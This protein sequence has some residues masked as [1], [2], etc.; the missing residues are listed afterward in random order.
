M[1]FNLFIARR[2]FLSNRGAKKV[3]RPAILIAT[4]GV[5]IG[6]AVMII[7][8]CVVLGFKQE[9][10]S[11]VI[12][13]GSHVQI[14]NYATLASNS[15]QPIALPPAF[16]REIK[17]V[18]GVAHVQR[19]CNKEGII[20][21]E[22]EFKGI[23]LKGVGPE[24]DPSFLKENLVAGEIPTFSD[25][26]SSNKI[27][28][29]KQV[30]DELHLKVGSRVYAYFF[31][32]S[33]RTR[34]FT[35]AGIYCTHLTEFD[36]VFAFTDLYACNRLNAWE[37][38]QYSCLEIRVKD[39]EQL[40]QVTSALV[41][42]VNRKVDAY[43]G[44]YVAMNI[45]ELYP[46]IFDW[47]DLLDVNVW[48]ILALMVAVAGFTM[49]SGL[50]ILILERTNF[51]GIMKALGSTNRGIRHIF[52]YFSVFVIGKG[53]LWGNVIGIGLVILQREC[54]LIHLDASTYYVDTVPVL[55]NWGYIVAINAATLLIC[56]LALIVPSFLVSRI[57]PAQSI[58]FE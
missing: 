18:P 55:F 12:G 43:G 10:R 8:V 51:I 21:T 4:T 30:A 20:K 28:I 5:A 41:Q 24:F 17:E 37:A 9:I 11:K 50:L 16:V 58:R 25:S 42:H 47:L 3:S 13:F 46:Q 49:I 26:T 33:I 53:L 56:V 45:R 32:N 27:V 44:S 54:G 7:S 40:D 48:V 38:D 15:P 1:N 29:S 57:H 35:V 2:L 22:D 36:K 23:L 14:Q 52:L 34:R 6:L 39:F 31:E 19:F